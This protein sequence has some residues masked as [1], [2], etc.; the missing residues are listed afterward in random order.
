MNLREPGIAEQTGVALTLELVPLLEEALAGLRAGTAERCLS[1]WSAGNLY[2]FRHAHDYRYHAGEYA[3]ITG[4]TYDGTPYVIPLFELNRAPAAVLARLAATGR[5]FYPLSPGQFAQLD[6]Q[7]F[8][9]SQSRDDADYL[10][11]ADNFRFYR[12]TTL[13]KKRNLM[14]QLLAAHT[15]QAQP[16]AK[17]QHG[18]ALQVLQG[19]MHD[20]DKGPQEADYA[21]CVEALEHA[22]LLGLEGFMFH[23]DGEPAG[24]LLAQELEPGVFVIRFAKGLDRY[25]G[26]AQYMFHYFCT[27]FP[28]PVQW[29]NFEQDMG[30]E[31][32]RQ[33]KASYQPADLLDKFR[34]RL[35]AAT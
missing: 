3:H 6:T 12:G 31:N 23:A 28:R 15:V 19:W 7:R 1:D 2:L 13:G 24:F 5:C 26:M 27:H 29:L 20:R 25:K 16:L 4:V 34:V 10:Y 22:S 11:P 30:L 35:R 9:C 18:A 14:K 21:A 17:P 33:T 32:F 8:T